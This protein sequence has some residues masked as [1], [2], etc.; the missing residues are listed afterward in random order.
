MV[1]EA[2]D[3]GVSSCIV[4]RAEDTFAHPEMKSLLHQWGLSGEDV[5]LAFVC[6]GYVDGAYPA[7]KE[8]KPGRVIFAE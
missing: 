6:L 4:G 2:Y 7:L 5:P 8:R 1:L 3:L